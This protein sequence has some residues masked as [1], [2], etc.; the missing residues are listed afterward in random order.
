MLK[1]WVDKSDF[2]GAL[3]QRFPLTVGSVKSDQVL[4]EPR[5]TR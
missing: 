2:E 1:K 5:L 3:S 4:I